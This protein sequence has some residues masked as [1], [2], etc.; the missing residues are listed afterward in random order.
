M[1]P[2][3]PAKDARLEVAGVCTNPVSSILVRPEARNRHTGPG[4]Q[5]SRE[6]LRDDLPCAAFQLDNGRRLCATVRQYRLVIPEG[7]QAQCCRLVRV[8]YESLIQLAEASR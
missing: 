8:R 1:L 5:N 2:L 4:Y 3:N 7:F 6:R